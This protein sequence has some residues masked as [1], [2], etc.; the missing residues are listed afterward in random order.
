MLN[1]EFKFRECFADD[2]INHSKV[3]KQNVE[4]PHSTKLFCVMLDS[5]NS[6]YRYK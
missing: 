3:L 4:F 2:V 5:D 1:F 6:V